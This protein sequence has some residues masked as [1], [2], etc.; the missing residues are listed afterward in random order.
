MLGMPCLSADQ[1]PSACAYKQHVEQQH[2]DDQRVGFERLQRRCDS[3]RGRIIGHGLVC[4]RS[5]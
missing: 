2:A 3:A 1:I 5:G 4:L